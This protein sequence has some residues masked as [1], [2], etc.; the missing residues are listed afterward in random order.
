MLQENRLFRQ[1]DLGLLVTVIALTICGL[2]AIFSA[3]HSSESAIIKLNFKRQLIWVTFGCLVLTLT[4]LIPNRFYHKYAYHAYAIT[5]VLLVVVLFI[6]T[7]AGTR[8]WLTIGPV[9]IQPVEFAKI[10]AVMALAKYLSQDHRKLD[11]VLDVS[12]AFAIVIMPMILVVRQPDLG[13]SLVFLAVI[14]PILHWAGLSHI[15]L[16]ALTA[17]II[18]LVCA[19]NYYSFLIAMIAIS[20]VLLLSRR[21]MMF[22]LTNFFINI[23]VGVF[24]PIIWNLLKEYQKQRILTFLGLVT[25]PQGLGYQVIQSKVAIGSGGFFGKGFLQGT[26]T[27]L[28]FLPE[29]HTDFIFCVI[30]EEF[31]FVGAIVIL[32]LFL[33]LILRCIGI[34]VNARTKFESLLVFGCT[35]IFLFQISVN[36]GMTIGIMPVTGIPLPFL[37]YG[38]S[39]LIMSFVGVG[40]ALNAARKRFEYD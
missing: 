36:I 23:G 35:I 24:T 17:P 20:V 30:G 31:G 8:R 10:G 11:K 21:G 15:A 26:Q 19:F 37:S 16:F 1:I 28:R 39:S 2:M 25:D 29:Q 22:F 12:I 38:G 34:S 4:A 3:T 33:F 7:G 18:S 13:S 6:G 40:L 27:H 14:L 5:F 32:S 9:W